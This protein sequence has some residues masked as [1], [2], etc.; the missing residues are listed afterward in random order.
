ME[1]TIMNQN[2]DSGSEDEIKFHL[3]LVLSHAIGH[4]MAEIVP[5]LES[6]VRLPNISIPVH[7]LATHAQL[8][9]RELS[10]KT[11]ALA[12]L[13]GEPDSVS[14]PKMASYEL[15]QFFD[16]FT[17]QVNHALSNKMR[18][19]VSYVLDSETEPD[20]IFDARRI[21]VILYHLIS[22]SLQHG[23]TD[24]KNVKLICKSTKDTFELIVRDYG[25]GIPTEMHPTLFT[26]FQADYNMKQ[27]MLGILPPRIQGLGLPLCRKL[28]RDMDGE[29]KFRN[30]R[31]GAQFTVTV[32][33]RARGFQEPL[34]FTPDDTL[35]LRCMAPLWLYLEDM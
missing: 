34:E 13:F 17:E 21:S 14:S 6:V 7:K 8:V 26:K 30:Y 16:V 12:E 23:R 18:C 32:P 22:N 31:S 35:M 5:A 25:G 29:L 19:K 11:S 28:I 9:A 33:Q 20:V 10:A 4:A 15:K 3:P 27:N 2:Y 1:N 24:N